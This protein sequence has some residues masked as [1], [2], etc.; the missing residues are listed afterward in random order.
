MDSKLIFLRQAS[1]LHPQYRLN[2]SKQRANA[3]L[4]NTGGGRGG[5]LCRRF[6]LE[7]GN[8]RS[9][10][11]G[12]KTTRQ[13]DNGSLVPLY[14]RSLLFTRAAQPVPGARVSTLHRR[15]A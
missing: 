13:Q 9:R 2:R 7:A 11:Q 6:I 14:P 5:T 4:V 8:K 12:N 3:V 1:T 10:E 15:R